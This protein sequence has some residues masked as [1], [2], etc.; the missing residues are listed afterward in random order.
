M[1]VSYAIPA[2]SG[3]TAPLLAFAADFNR[4]GAATMLYTY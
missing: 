3:R 4:C 2:L 1:V